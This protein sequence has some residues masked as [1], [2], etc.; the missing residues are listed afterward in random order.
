MTRSVTRVLAVLVLRELLATVF[1]APGVE[2]VRF[3]IDGDCEAYS[4][5]FEG[6][7][8]RLFERAGH[9]PPIG[10]RPPPAAPAR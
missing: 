9:A 2:A 6:S 5:Y 10:S 4:R 3:T 7:G 1:A 8:C